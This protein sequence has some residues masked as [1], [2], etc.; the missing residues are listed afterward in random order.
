MTP[1][2]DGTPCDDGDKLTAADACKA[3]KCAPGLQS[4]CTKQAD[5]DAFEDGDLCNGTLFCDLGDGTCKVNSA[6]VIV[7]PS[8][9]DTDCMKNTCDAETGACNLKAVK[10]GTGCDDDDKCS[11]G[12]ICLGGACGQ[13]KNVCI[14]TTDAQCQSQDDGDLCNGILF[15]D[16]AKGACTH[17]PSSVITCPTVDD[18][19]CQKRT[20]APKT[21]ACDLS[22]QPTGTTCDDGDKCTVGDVCDPTGCVPGTF[23]CTCKSDDDCKSQDDG[24]L[25]NGVLFCDKSAKLPTCKPNP[26]SVVSCPTVDDTDCRRNECQPKTGKCGFSPV[27]DASACSDGDK[28]ATG[29]LCFQAQCKPG[30]YTCACKVDGDCL[31]QDD[32]D[33]CNGV[34]YCDVSGEVPQC[35]PNPASVV[36]CPKTDDTQCLTSA[37]DPKTGKCQVGPKPVDTPCSDGSVCTSKD[38]CKA[39]KCVGAALDCDDNDVCTTDGC[40]P[41]KGCTHAS[42]NCDDGN[43]CTVD[44][45]DAGKCS[46]SSKDTD[47]KI[48]NADGNGCTVNDI[49]GAGVCKAGPEIV[50]S[51]AGGPCQKPACVSLGGHNFQCSLVPRNEGAVCTDEKAC[52]ATGACNKGL[53]EGGSTIDCEDGEFCSINTCKVGQGCV[54]VDLADATTCTS[55]KACTSG[56]TCSK[57]KC[58]GGGAK[59]WEQLYG[60]TIDTAF[61]D[62]AAFADGSSTVAGW[63]RDATS[64]S[65]DGLLLRLDLH[66]KQQWSRTFG[67]SEDQQLTGVVALADGGVATVGRL[68]LSS[69]ALKGTWV[70][71]DAAGKT[72]WTSD[73]G[74]R[75][76]RDL[77]ATGSGGFF[78]GGD[79]EG[80]YQP[81]WIARLDGVG[82][83]AWTTAFPSA[84]LSRIASLAGTADGGVVAV[85]EANNLPLVVAADA[86]G[87]KLWVNRARGWADA[88]GYLH[89][90]VQAPNGDVMVAGWRAPGS[91][92]T[93][94]TV[95]LRLDAVSGAVRRKTYIAHGVGEPDAVA[96]AVDSGGQTTVISRHYKADKAPAEMFSVTVASD[97]DTVVAQRVQAPQPDTEVQGGV[98]MPGGGFLVVGRAKTGSA[99]TYQGWAARTDPWAAFGCADSGKCA[100]VGAGCDDGDPCTLERCIG[101]S[102]CLAIKASMPCDDGDACST[103]G[104]CLDGACKAVGKRFDVTFA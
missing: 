47:K 97:D 25:C 37:C 70:R 84:P 98:A 65:R 48:C 33:L 61:D 23:I 59:L 51:V 19:A 28:C 1:V 93:S 71:V 14:C 32:G 3:G 99:A 72:L 85:G 96:I 63:V 34:P 8:A 86:L 36:W 26:A 18:T 75:K 53:C 56:E 102:G 17:D 87:N 73:L 79:D 46:Y 104:L 44:S 20:C 22:A 42:S 12:E 57:G 94:A 27:A 4:V 35:K 13:G 21:G 31:A 29:D 38:R 15:C 43:E 91:G 67:G 9:G 101:P 58:G 24:D 100:D 49:C 76:P 74:A 11:V 41:V 81:A 88:F 78:V 45:C 39:D 62:V 55:G 66:G 10:N 60:G 6:T 5:C 103:A 54:A 68:S 52:R 83:V 80:G 16:K 69:A 2:A 95:L 82:K 89:Q 92:L 77:A 50:C 90:V 30:T 40:D 64:G 7:C